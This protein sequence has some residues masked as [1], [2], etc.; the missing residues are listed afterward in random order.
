MRP[1]SAAPA[2]LIRGEQPA[3]I[4]V[5]SHYLLE[6]HGCPFAVLND[7][8]AVEQALRE[9]ARAGS[10]T[11]VDVVVHAFSPH[12]VTGLVILEESH[13]SVH[14][15]PE[16]GYAAADVFT[17]GSR[18]RPDRACTSLIR[19]LGAAHYSLR[20]IPREALRSAPLLPVQAPGARA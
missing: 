12:G 8:A 2:G 3:G 13:L 14:T 7:P 17:C 1:R 16:L 18:V 15:W 19:R 10:L 5:G 6:L 4:R 20:C 9:S 11:V